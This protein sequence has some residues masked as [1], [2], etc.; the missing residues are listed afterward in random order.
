MLK[1][2]E[3]AESFGGNYCAEFWGFW[4]LCGAWSCLSTYPVTGSTLPRA[5]S[6]LR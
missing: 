4:T 6:T 1:R 3:I 2:P 5:Q